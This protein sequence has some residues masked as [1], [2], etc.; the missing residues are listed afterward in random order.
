MFVLLNLE[1][2]FTLILLL[3]PGS[4]ILFSFMVRKRVSVVGARR[5]SAALDRFSFGSMAFDLALE[6]AAARKLNLFIER[7]D[8][9][10]KIL[11][12]AVGD[13][14][15]FATF[16]KYFLEFF[17]FLAILTL[18]LVLENSSFAA[19]SGSFSTVLGIL[20]IATFRLLPS[21]QAL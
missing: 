8:L 16:P 7:F 19:G 20:L 18:G 17:V 6:L 3:L 10:S 1:P 4:Y 13:G 5:Q 11:A 12:K 2:V 15:I 21:I 14:I 9:K